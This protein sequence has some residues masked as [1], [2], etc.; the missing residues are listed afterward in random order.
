MDNEPKGL[1]GWIDGC[2][3]MI[4]LFLALTWPILL[5]MFMR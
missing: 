4:G 1:W 2:L 5:L 3:M